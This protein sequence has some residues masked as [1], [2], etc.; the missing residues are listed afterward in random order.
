MT[1]QTPLSGCV[2]VSGMPGAGKSTVTRLAARLLPR[3]AQVKADDLNEMI[4]SGRVWALGQPADEAARQQELCERNLTSV[5]NNF[6]DFG[7]TVLMDELV[8]DRAELDLLL[9]LTAPRPVAL[10]TLAPRIDVCEHRN[11]RRDPDESWQ[12]DG[13]VELE[14]TLWRELG[15]A[16]WWFD[17]SDLSPEETAEQIV[18][19]AWTRGVIRK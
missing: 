3:A 18:R 8:R 7:F 1:M 4:L 14:A 17:T 12:F 9:R 15:D 11:A 2:I 10:V 13:Y 19:D 5:A 6:V 16:G